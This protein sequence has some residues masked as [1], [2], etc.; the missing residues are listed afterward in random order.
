LARIEP[1][2]AEIAERH[3][4]EMTV[5]E[6]HARLVCGECASRRVDVVVTGT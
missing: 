3:G 6:W 2:P 5:R 4:A 1:D